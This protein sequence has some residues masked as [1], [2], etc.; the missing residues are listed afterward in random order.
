MGLTLVEVDS[1]LG[2]GGESA[3]FTPAEAT[4]KVRRIHR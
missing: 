1:G 3:T 4:A 2:D